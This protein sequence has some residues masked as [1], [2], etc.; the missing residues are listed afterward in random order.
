MQRSAEDLLKTYL[1]E[2]TGKQVLAGRTKRGEGEKIHAVGCA[3]YGIR[4]GFPIRF[5]LRFFFAL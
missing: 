5:L 1:G 3:T 2:R 4:L